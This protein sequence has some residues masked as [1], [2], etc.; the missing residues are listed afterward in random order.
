[1]KI[2]G[3]PIL[4]AISLSAL[5]LVGIRARSSSVPDPAPVLAASIP[6]R[7]LQGARDEVRRGVTYRAAYEDISYPGG[8]VRRD[9][10]VCTDVIIRSFRA[11][12][13]DLQK[14]VHEDMKAHFSAYPRNWGLS[15]PDTN[16]DHRRAPNLAAF[17]RRHGRTLPTDTSYTTLATWRPGD[18]IMWKLDNGLDH[19]GIVSDRK[20]LKGFPLVI[21]NISA[22]SEEDAPTTWKIT[23]HYR[24]PKE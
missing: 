5:V 4:L 10:G 24:Y 1:M 15:H 8:D 22:T 2:R 19:C 23:G 17:F 14:L 3:V 7:I 9:H 21:H 13:F 6:G 12:G 18:V 11:A 16:I 20:N